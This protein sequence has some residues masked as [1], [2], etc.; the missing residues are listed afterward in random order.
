MS[1]LLNT[2]T[3]RNALLVVQRWELQRRMSRFFDRNIVID[4]ANWQQALQE[5]DLGTMLGALNVAHDQEI[6]DM[7][8]LLGSIGG[9]DVSI[10]DMSIN[11]DAVNGSDVTGTGSGLRPYATLWFMPFLPRVINHKYRILIH[12]DIDLD[13]PLSIT[14]TIGPEGCLSFIGVSP[15]EEVNQALASSI[16]STAI[17]QGTWNEIGSNSAV[18]TALCKSFVQMTSGGE[19]DKAAPVNR[20]DVANS[21]FWFRRAG[22]VGLAPTD[23]FRFIRPRHSFAMTTL[24]IDT[25][26]SRRVL[27][28]ADY[29]CS[30]VN[31]INLRIEMNVGIG[32]QIMS[33]RGLPVGFWFCQISQGASNYP[34]EIRTDVNAWN[35]NDTMA[36]LQTVA[37]VTIANLFLPPVGSPAFVGVQFINPGGAEYSSGDRII[38]VRGGPLII[39]GVDCMAYWA[40]DGAQANLYGNS[41]KILAPTMSNIMA[42]YCAMDPNNPAANAINALNTRMIMNS[43]LWGNCNYAAVWTQCDVTLFGGGGDAAGTMTA[44]ATAGHVMTAQSRFFVSNP[45]S[46]TGAPVGFDLLFTDPAVAL[47]FAFPAVNS[48]VTDAL[49]NN[50]T[51]AT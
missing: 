10:A 35:P 5:F 20:V 22:M 42:T 26:G 39:K 15:E 51:R 19:Q 37:Q 46:G 43:C 9:L 47:N 44:I 50:A 38:V 4:F 45:W 30:K 25:I 1:N 12:E 28:M 33:L 6:L 13:G 29:Q 18:T 48:I 21:M 36:D 2:E 34:I 41:W 40:T 11:V 14:N 31:F 23:T 8:S 3:G 7:F 32:E 24:D 17:H 27:N 49:A 16:L